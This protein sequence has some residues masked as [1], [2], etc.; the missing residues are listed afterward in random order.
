MKA[1]LIRPVTVRAKIGLVQ[2]VRSSA[3]ISG[4]LPSI[5]YRFAQNNGTNPNRRGRDTEMRQKFGRIV[6]ICHSVDY[7]SED[8]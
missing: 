6:K 7:V 8:L 4:F 3:T 2:I 5:V 1:W